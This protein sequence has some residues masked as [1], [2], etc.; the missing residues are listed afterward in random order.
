MPR[1]HRQGERLDSRM[2][3]MSYVC[4]V[5]YTILDNPQEIQGVSIDQYGLTY[6]DP[7]LADYHICNKCVQYRTPILE[8]KEK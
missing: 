8:M 3:R 2:K 1:L 6:C 7:I 4:N 5:C